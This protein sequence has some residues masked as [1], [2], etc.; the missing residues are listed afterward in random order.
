MFYALKH[1]A[2]VPAIVDCVD[3][4]EGTVLAAMQ[5]HYSRCSCIFERKDLMD[6]NL[7][8]IYPGREVRVDQH[9]HQPA[10]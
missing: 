6:L 2:G 9:H 4:Q 5:G 7:D 1:A 3:R 10:T 8:E